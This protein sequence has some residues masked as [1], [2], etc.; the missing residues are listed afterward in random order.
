KRT[1]V[2]GL[3][4]G[5]FSKLLVHVTEVVEGVGQRGIALRRQREGL[6]R[7][8]PVSGGDGLHALLEEFLA[9]LLPD[10]LRRSRRGRRGGTGGRQCRGQSSDSKLAV[11]H[12]NPARRGSSPRLPRCSADLLGRC[13]VQDQDALPGRRLLLGVGAGGSLLGRLLGLTLDTALARLGLGVRRRGT[14]VEARPDA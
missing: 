8:L 4:R 3:R 1:L 14:G 7:R 12:V 6:L 11:A 2:G 5:E 9:R 13:L 10:L